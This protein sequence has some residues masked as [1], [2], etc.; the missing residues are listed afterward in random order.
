MVAQGYFRTLVFPCC[1]DGNSTDADNANPMAGFVVNE[2][3]VSAYFSG[4][5]PLGT[6]ISVG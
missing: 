5:D 4:R 1:V 6:S 2:S 3:F